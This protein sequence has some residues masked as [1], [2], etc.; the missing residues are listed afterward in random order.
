MCV[1][2]CMYVY[3]CC[4]FNNDENYHRNWNIAGIIIF[5]IYGLDV[6]IPEEKA[7]A[8]ALHP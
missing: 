2:L 7:S 3:T 8:S 4:F 6:V 1:C 5:L